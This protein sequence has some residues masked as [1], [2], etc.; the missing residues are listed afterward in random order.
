MPAWL[1]LALTTQPSMAA[2]TLST[3]GDCSEPQH[4]VY[5]LLDDSTP[6]SHLYQQVRK[7]L[8]QGVTA[9]R[10]SW[11]NESGATQTSLVE[12]YGHN[13]PVVAVFGAGHVGQ[14][15]IDVLQH[16]DIELVWIDS[17]KDL[18]SE[19]NHAGINIAP[20]ARPAQ[21][22]AQLPAGSLC[23]IMTHNH[24]LD[25]DICTT[26]L[27]RGDI[28]FCGLI[29]STSKRRRFERLLKQ[30][31][32]AELSAHLTCPIGV[33][34]ISGKTPREVAIAVSAQVLQQLELA[35]SGMSHQ[36]E[37]VGA[38]LSH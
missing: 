34:G 2:F 18:F 28:P 27:Q 9:A 24:T 36:K 6:D 19:L 33:D 23:L 35:R 15:V 12:I 3:S 10:L 8:S 25:F 26:L 31:G 20:H 4:E 21:F 37:A 11:Q 38:A 17:R 30:A 7:L 5:A 32:L 22:A 16:L 13:R 1:D 29:G 14:A